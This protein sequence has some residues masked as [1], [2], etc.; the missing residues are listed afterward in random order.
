MVYKPEPIDTSKVQLSDEILDL[1]ERLAE[2]AHEV[3]AQRRMAEGWRP[4]PRRDEAKKEHPSLVPYKELPEG[5]KEYDRSTALETLKVLL[6]LG[7][8]FEKAPQ[9]GLDTGPGPDRERYLD[10]KSTIP[11][12][13]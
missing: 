4:G 9:S 6:A 10:K 1:T 11:R 5:E 7:Y 2:N 8:R 12:Q 13:E 3:W